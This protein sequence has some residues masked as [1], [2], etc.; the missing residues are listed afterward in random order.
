MPAKSKKRPKRADRNETKCF[1]E[2]LLQLLNQS[3]G[4]W[5]APGSQTALAERLNVSVQTMSDWLNGIAAPKFE[6]LFNISQRCNLSVDWLMF[7]RGPRD[8]RASRALSSVTDDLA[9]TVSTAVA[10]RVGLDADD[11][12]ADGDALLSACVEKAAADFEAFTSEQ[13]A[14][15]VQREGTLRALSIVEALGEELPRVLPMANS[16]VLGNELAHVHEQ[17]LSGMRDGTTAPPV[18]WF[19]IDE[20]P[21]HEPWCS[22]RHCAAHGERMDRYWRHM[23]GGTDDAR[24]RTFEKISFTRQELASIPTPRAKRR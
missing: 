14:L 18:V 2:R 13:S 19:R 12:R 24:S 22:C 10:A 9:R 23:Y 3:D 6:Q 8:A 20:R 1:R 5:I 7:D 16:Q 17:L 21:A 4:A 15:S 11:L